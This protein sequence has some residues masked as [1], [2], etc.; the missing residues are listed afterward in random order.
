MKKL[1][2]AQHWHERVRRLQCVAEEALYIV[3]S[4][5][6]VVGVA[7]HCGQQRRLAVGH[8]L[9]PPE[10]RT[11]CQRQTRPCV[12][13]V[14]PPLCPVCSKNGFSGDPNELAGRVFLPS[15]K[16]TSAIGPADRSCC[17]SVCLVCVCVRDHK[18]HSGVC[19]SPSFLL[20]PAAKQ[21]NSRQA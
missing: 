12:A 7:F 4:V 6:E 17:V 1:D 10:W 13:S 18:T 14:C 5:V 2:K 19:S 11:S 16:V 3:P 9:P 20:H 8:Q 21:G 15:H